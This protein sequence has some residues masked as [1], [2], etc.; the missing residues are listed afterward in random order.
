[1]T[2]LVGTPSQIQFAWKEPSASGFANPGVMCG[3]V[4][5]VAAA[6]TES[7][8]AGCVFVPCS[9]NRK[10]SS[11]VYQNPEHVTMTTA[12]VSPYKGN[13]DGNAYAYVVKIWGSGTA[14][15]ALPSSP[16]S[17]WGYGE[18]NMAYSVRC[19]ADTED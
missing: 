9:G 14:D 3:Q 19:V 8:M 6:A 13:N 17:K 7:D 1:M 2:A 16:E 4:N 5:S 15:Y 12:I 11:G 10:W 18:L